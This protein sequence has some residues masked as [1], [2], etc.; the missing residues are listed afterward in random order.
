MKRQ[1]LIMSLILLL[2]LPI[3]SLK[4]QDETKSFEFSTSGAVFSYTGFY[5]TSIEPGDEPFLVLYEYKIGA[6]VRILTI[7][8]DGITNRDF[9]VRIKYSSGT[10][11]Q[12]ILHY[13]P[14]DDGNYKIRLRIWNDSSASKTFGEV[15]AFKAEPLGQNRFRMTLEPQPG[16]AVYA[17]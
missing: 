7:F 15:F 2:L 1:W 10:L 17:K 9:N 3:K 8:F 14:E 5:R 4:A 16:Q 12:P 11:P 13:A 6:L